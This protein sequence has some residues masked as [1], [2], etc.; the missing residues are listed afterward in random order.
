[1]ADCLISL[2][3]GV[4]ER[5]A[6]VGVIGAQRDR[7]LAHRATGF[8]RGADRRDELGEVPPVTGVDCRRL[9][10]SRARLEGEGSHQ[11]EQLK[12]AGVPLTADEARLL[13][14]DS[15]V[16]GFVPTTA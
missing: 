11:L 2:L 8:E 14:S 10:R 1:M 15:S 16:P 12:A 5:G 4:G 6:Q 3:D 13:S 7:Q 9:P